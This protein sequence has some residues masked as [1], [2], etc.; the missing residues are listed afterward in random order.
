MAE[1]MIGKSGGGAAVPAGGGFGSG[2][3]IVSASAEASEGYASASV[4]KAFGPTGE[5]FGAPTG[6]STSVESG[7]GSASASVNYQY[8]IEGG[9]IIIEYDE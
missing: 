9:D 8:E 4:T 5:G 3:S 2:G 6:M 1:E 7:G